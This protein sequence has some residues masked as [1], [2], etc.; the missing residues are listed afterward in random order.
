ME[1]RKSKLVPVS[2]TAPTEREQ[3]DTME[4]QTQQKVDQHLKTLVHSF[5]ATF[6]IY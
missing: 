4:S 1:T 2:M 3:G 5:Y 6:L